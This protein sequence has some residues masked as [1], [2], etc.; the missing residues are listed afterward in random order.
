M[1]SEARMAKAKV[2]AKSR[3]GG[4]KAAK[5]KRATPRTRKLAA[6]AQAAKV[7]RGKSP[8]MAEGVIGRIPAAPEAAPAGAMKALI[9]DKVLGK[10]AWNEGL[11]WYQSKI[12]FRNCPVDLCVV[13]E[14]KP[15]LLADLLDRS[16][17]VISRLHVLAHK[18]EDAAKAK[19]RE[20]ESA[21]IGGAEVVPPRPER[22][23]KRYMRLKAVE[24]HASG[25]V[26]F[27]HDD[28]N[29][30]WGHLIETTM[31]SDAQVSEAKLAA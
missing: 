4:A 16:R 13:V 12:K 20:L 19:I 7:V 10:L 1:L 21:R 9:R 30:F 3:S 2:A 31:T 22:K 17:A 5:G 29:A 24:I 18:A 26:A 28:G 11:G 14:D 15:E 27:L 6:R 25:R 8:A 23:F